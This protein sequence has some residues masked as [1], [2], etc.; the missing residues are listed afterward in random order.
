MSM[1][2][3]FKML[4]HQAKLNIA[5]VSSGFHQADWSSTLVIV[6]CYIIS[7]LFWFTCFSRNLILRICAYAH[8]DADVQ[9]YLN[10]RYIYNK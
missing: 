1:L 2:Q 7:F 8:L 4:S 3:M 5:E 10:L 9:L 6:Y